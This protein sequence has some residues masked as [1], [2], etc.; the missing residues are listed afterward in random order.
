M[1]DGYY[2]WLGIPKGQRPPTPYQLLRIAPDEQDPEVIEAAAVRL[3]ARVRTFQLGPHASECTRILTELVQAADTLINPTK[4][5]QYDAGHAPAA[6]P[7][8]GDRHGLDDTIVEPELYLPVIRI[9]PDECLL[10]ARPQGAPCSLWPRF[11]LGMIGIAHCLLFYAGYV[12]LLRPEPAGA[13][14]IDRGNPGGRGVPTARP[15]FV[16]G[17]PGIRGRKPAPAHPPKPP[18]WRLTISKSPLTISTDDLTNW[19]RTWVATT[20]TIAT[21]TTTTIV[22]T[23][24]TPLP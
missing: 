14:P 8:Q 10:H 9:E 19:R 16:S 3:S 17:P 7:V 1:F 24:A 22:T 2:E 15:E 12:F 18:T 4:R 11:A 5:A 23:T 6:T 13:L 21:T 20:I